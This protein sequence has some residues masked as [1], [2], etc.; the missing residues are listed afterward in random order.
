[1]AKIKRNFTT[2]ARAGVPHGSKG[3]H[4]LIV[5][6][7]L[8]DLAQLDKGT[9]MK[10]PQCTAKNATTAAGELVDLPPDLMRKSL[11]PS[12][13]VTAMRAMVQNAMTAVSIQ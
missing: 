10:I 1:M 9:A 2:I 8:S 5:G 6:E 13:G 4:N 12:R 11:S 7:I 3:K